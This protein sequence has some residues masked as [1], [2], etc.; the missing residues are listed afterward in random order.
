MG[1]S[2][3]GSQ[4][5]IYLCPFLFLGLL[6]LSCAPTIKYYP[7][8]NQYLIHQDYDSASRLVKENKGVFGTRNAVLYYLDEGLVAHFASRYEQSNQSLSKAESIIDELYTKSISKE[9]ASFLISDNTI[10]YRGED[11]ESA[12][13]NLFMALNYVGLGRW[14]DALV[15]ARKV[16]NKLNVFNAQY[17]EDKRNVYKEDAFIRFLMGVLYE[18][19]GEINDAFISYRKAE[20]IY[21]TDYAPNYG[22]TAP[23][24]LIENLSTAGQTMEFDEEVGD[25]QR[26]YP[27]VAHKSLDEKEDMAEVYFIHYNG[28]GPEKVERSFPVPMPDQYVAKIAYPKFERRSYRIS[29]SE[30]SLRGVSSGSSHRFGTELMEDIAS[31]AVM[32][33]DNRIGRVKAKAIARATTKY[34][35]AKGAEMVAEHEGG[36]LLG[37]IVKAAAQAASWATEQADVRHWRLLPAG[38]RVGRVIVPSGEYEAI[39]KFVDVNGSVVRSRQIAPFAVKKGEKKFFMFRTLN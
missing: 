28:L 27:G 22:V 18:A 15:E 20:E 31:M 21:R 33:L 34:L 6:V 7:Q 13:V 24:F 17:A 10:P 38:I 4:K 26:K 12:L 14:E 36:D 2:P 32:N 11:F 37:L 9:A 16:D 5:T 19:E 1:T 8:L 29:G 3:R 30:I 23:G 25:I 39:I 35:A